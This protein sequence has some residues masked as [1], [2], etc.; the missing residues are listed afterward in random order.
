MLRST[1]N[2]EERGIVIG[3]PTL[4]R[5]G[6]NRFRLLCGMCGEICFV[7]DTTFRRASRAIFEGGDNPFLCRGCEE[8]EEE[9]VWLFAE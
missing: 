7:D 2:P 5:T 4:Y 8:A 1:M 6:A 3:H 9:E